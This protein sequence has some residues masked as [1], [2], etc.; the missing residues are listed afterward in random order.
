MTDKVELENELEVHDGMDE[1][2]V[3]KISE[4]EEETPP[5]TLRRSTRQRRHPDRYNYGSSSFR[6]IFSLSS[7][8]D[9]PRT[10]KEA[11]DMEDKESWRLVVDEEMDALRKNDKWDLV[12]VPNG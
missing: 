5:Q 9:E 12:P 7:H 2:E 10:M 3:S 6:C 11:M 1:E 8:T 4:E